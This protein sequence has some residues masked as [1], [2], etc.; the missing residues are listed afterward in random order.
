VPKLECQILWPP[1]LIP[2]R[3][4]SKNKPGF[5]A[6]RIGFTG[7]RNDEALSL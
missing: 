4:G 7:R 6:A 1:G 2:C 3:V 5:E